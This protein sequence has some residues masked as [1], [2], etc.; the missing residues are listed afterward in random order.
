[1]FAFTW[2]NCR[3]GGRTGRVSGV[4]GA[5]QVLRTQVGVGGINFSGKKRYER[6]RFNVISV[7]R[8]CVGVQFPENKRYVTLE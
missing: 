5:I 7:T 1:M 4:F 8:E 6:V 2:G 3:L